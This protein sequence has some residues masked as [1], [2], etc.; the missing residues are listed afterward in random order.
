MAAMLSASR[1]LTA[2]TSSLLCGER[3]AAVRWRR[4]QSAAALLCFQRSCERGRTRTGGVAVESESLPPL[5]S[6]LMGL[7]VHRRA[8]AYLAFNLSLSPLD[9]LQLHMQVL[10]LRR[11]RLHAVLEAARLLLG[12]PQLVTVDLVLG[13]HSHISG[14]ESLF[15]SSPPTNKSTVA[16][17]TFSAR[18]TA[19][20]C[21]L[22]CDIASGASDGFFTFS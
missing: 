13:K 7:R 10:V 12:P 6:V 11:Q 18:T 2:I 5:L 1:S 14:G 4:S 15:S 9:L 3:E 20:L 17:R 22:E 19:A 8:A 16:A 21:R